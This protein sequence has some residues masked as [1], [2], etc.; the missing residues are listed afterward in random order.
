MGAPR[1][2]PVLTDEVADWW[3]RLAPFIDSAIEYA[4]GTTS[5]VLLRQ[6][7]AP[8]ADRPCWAFAVADG[9]EVIG[10]AVTEDVTHPGGLHAL[11]VIALG[12]RRF[13]EWVDDFNAMLRRAAY[14]LGCEA[15]TASGRRGWVQKLRR[16]GW[17]EESVTVAMEIR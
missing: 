3:P 5:T 4:H 14:A 16:L 17:K 10:A 1:V 9:D 8:G 12:G 7:C 11:H 15:V 2:I 13:D 6:R